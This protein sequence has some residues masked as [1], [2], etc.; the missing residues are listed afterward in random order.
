MVMSSFH[1]FTQLNTIT[2]ESNRIDTL[3]E[4][5]VYVNEEFNV[6]Y[7][8]KQAKMWYF[9]FVFSSFVVHPAVNIHSVR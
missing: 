2:R 5:W 8:R 1:Y 3:G 4:L 7:H 6:I 9:S